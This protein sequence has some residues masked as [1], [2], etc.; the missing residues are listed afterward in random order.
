MEDF[1][2]Q[3][4]NDHRDFD[5]GRLEDNF[6]SSPFELFAK[7][8]QHAV[9]QKVPESNAFALSTVDAEG[10]SI[11]RILYLKEVLNEELVFYTNYGSDKAKNL[12]QNPKA[13]MLFFWP[14]LQQQIRIEGECAKVAPEV[15]D[16]Y[17]ASRPRGSKI[18]AW[19]SLQSSKLD[20]RE[21]LEQRVEEF[22]AKFP[23][24]VPRPPQWGGFALKPTK[25]EFWQGR[26]S[27]L[28]DRIVFEL[29]EGKWELYRIN[30]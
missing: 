14:A 15:S 16:E 27:R 13:G 4:K 29:K 5:F 17:F 28:H 30:P 9:E 12:E 25:F 23:D 2:E 19:A 26:P 18:G 7:W 20:S 3:L 22:A 10:Q 11:A 8:F 24:E 21:T 6:G 1:L